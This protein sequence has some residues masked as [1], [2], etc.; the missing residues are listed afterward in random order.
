MNTI[1][2]PKV[3]ICALSYN[4]GDFTDLAIRSALDAKY[5][6]LEI[7]CIDD[8]STDSSS[9]KLLALSQELGFDFYENAEN[10][11]IPSS[12]NRGL[13]LATGEYFILIGDDLMLPNRIQGDVDLLI[14]NPSVSFVCGAAKIIGQDGLVL[15]KYSNWVSVSPEGAFQE[16]PEQVWL[17]GSRIFTPTATYRTH[18]LRGLGG[19]DGDYDVEDRSMFIRFAK[20]GI[21]GWSRSDVTT[22]YR[23]HEGNF[24]AKFKVNMFEQELRLIKEFALKIAPW[25]VSAKFLIEAHYWMLFLGASSSQVAEALS[26]AGK[27]KMSWTTRSRL[28]KVAYLLLTFVKKSRYVER[29]VRNYLRSS[30]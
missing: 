5:P 25:K 11:G 2:A 12:C 10:K 14:D 17:N 6:N 22:L 27:G 20:E 1:K 9:E 8:G 15:E 30:D 4:T 26:L 3:T 18:I 19:W 21:S 28:F 23:R 29:N 13:S 16:S 24:S 7:I